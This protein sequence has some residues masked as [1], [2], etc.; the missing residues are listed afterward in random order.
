MATRG[1]TTGGVSSFYDQERS[2]DWS[3]GL[4][5][6][7]PLLEH[8]FDHSIGK[9]WQEDWNTYDNTATTGDYLLSQATTGE[10]AISATVPGSFALDSNSATQGQGA[11]LQQIKSYFVPAAG[12]HIWA[13]FN[14]AIEDTFDD[15]ELFIGLSVADTTIIVSQVNTSIDHIGWQCVTN[16]GVLLFTSEKNT[17]GDTSAAATL[18]ENA[19]IKLGFYVDGITSV[20]QFINGV[21]TGTAHATAN[22]PIGGLIPSAVCQTGGTADPIMHIGSCKIFQLR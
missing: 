1:L 14:I 6:T 20:Q 18:T 8:M 7:C 2:S 21:A 17:A 5:R 10:G 19:N 15:C 3:T 9:L 4:W 13:E 11:N 16:N 22:V 12:K